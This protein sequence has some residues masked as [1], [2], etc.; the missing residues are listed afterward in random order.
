[1]MMGQNI[2]D[3]AALAELI[4][5]ILDLLNSQYESGG[6]TAY[7]SCETDPGTGQLQSYTADW[8][9]GIGRFALLEAKI[10]AV[11]ELIAATEQF[12]KKTCR[13]GGPSGEEVTVNFQEI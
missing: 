7:A 11:A 6:F 12:R 4:G 2:G 5:A 1:M 10:N 13:I 8:P 3:T 9:A